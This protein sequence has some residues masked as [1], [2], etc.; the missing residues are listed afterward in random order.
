MIGQK[1]KAPAEN[2]HTNATQT[3]TRKGGKPNN[4]DVVSTV[5]PWGADPVGV[6]VGCSAEQRKA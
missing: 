6:L 3:H 4:R 5:T 2:T 1:S